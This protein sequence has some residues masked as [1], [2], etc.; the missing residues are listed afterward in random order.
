MCIWLLHFVLITS[1]HDILAA[2]EFNQSLC[3]AVTAANH[4]ISLLYQTVNLLCEVTVL[5]V[6][7]GLNI[8][9]FISHE[10]R[11]GRAKMLCHSPLPQRTF[12]YFSRLLK[13]EQSF[14]LVFF[15][16]SFFLSFLPLF[17]FF[18]FYYFYEELKLQ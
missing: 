4:Y 7:F 2:I 3:L 1:E 12:S 9:Y 5:Y 14:R 8:F 18:V 11:L 16:S 17:F 6:R 13:R 15:P 10:K